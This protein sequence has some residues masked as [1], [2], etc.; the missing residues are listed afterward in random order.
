MANQG[1]EG[2]GLA[3]DVV[4]LHLQVGHERLLGHAVGHQPVVER[5]AARGELVHEVL[6]ELTEDGLGIGRGGLA[7]EALGQLAGH[8]VLLELGNRLLL[9]LA[10][11]LGDGLAHGGDV[12]EAEVVLRELVGQLGELALDEAVEGDVNLG[13]DGLRGLLALGGS[14]LGHLEGD[15]LLVARLHADEALVERLGHGAHAELVEAVLE[16]DRVGV[17]DALALEVDRVAGLDGAALDVLILAEVAAERLDL[18]VDLGLGGLLGRQGDLDRVER[19]QLELGTDGVAHLEGEVLAVLDGLGVGEGRV[20][21]RNDVLLLENLR[22]ERVDQRLG[23]LGQDG[24]LADVVVDDGTRGMAGTESREAVLLRELLVGV[25]DSLLHVFC[26]YRDG[27]LD[28][29][30]LKT[31]CRCLQ[32]SSNLNPGRRGR[33]NRW[34][35]RKGSN[36]HGLPHWNLNPARL[37]IPP[38]PLWT[39]TVTVYQ[40]T[41]R[42]TPA[43]SEFCDFSCSGHGGHGMEGLG[44]AGQGAAGHRA[45]GHGAAGRNKGR[46]QDASSFDATRILT[47]K[48][49]AEF[50]GKPCQ[51]F[52]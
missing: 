50:P 36:L 42:A 48:A 39:V 43:H 19:G 5:G 47:R 33:P 29:I 11:L 15:L 1:I 22:L 31:L 40:K 45:A 13:D 2:K 35:G 25:R 27:D 38:R 46:D 12:G 16:V 30:V 34:C 18:G 17:L 41:R 4:G 8:A 51:F 6:A 37:P 28:H 52:A 7:L 26:V 3:G 44:S 23:G 32:R 21:H 14:G 24:G 10:N 20:A 49:G 9:L